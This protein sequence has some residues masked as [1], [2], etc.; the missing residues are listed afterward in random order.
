MGKLPERMIE[1]MATLS[2]EEERTLILAQSR[3]KKRRALLIT[4]LISVMLVAAFILVCRFWLNFIGF[5]LVI[6]LI[7]IGL[8][9]KL[10]GEAIG[11]ENQMQKHRLELLDEKTPHGKF[12]WE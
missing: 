7:L 5:S 8:T 12:K 9:V 2:Y 10:G 11:R 3:K 4:L 1:T 6:F